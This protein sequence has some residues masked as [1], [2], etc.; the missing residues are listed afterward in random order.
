MSSVSNLFHTN[1][2]KIEFPK[3]L[4]LS[5]QDEKIVNLVFGK[6]MLSICAGL[7]IACAGMSFAAT[8]LYSLGIIGFLVLGLL[9]I[10]ATYK[11][12]GIDRFMHKPLPFQKNQPVGLPNRG[13][14]CWANSALQLIMNNPNLEERFR[15]FEVFNRIID[16]YRRYQDREIAICSEELSSF[17]V[18][19][20]MH[21]ITNGAVDV[22]IAQEDPAVIFENLM[23]TMQTN[24]GQLGSFYTFSQRIGDAEANIFPESMVSVVISEDASLTTSVNSY[25]DYI[26][27]LGRRI[28]R[29]FAESPELLMIEIRRNLFD[30]SPDGTFNGQ[31]KDSREVLVDLDMNLDA[32]KFEDGIERRYQCSGFIVHQ[33]KNP[34]SG[35][36][37][38]Y[39]K[40][41][42]SWWYC[43]DEEVRKAPL[44]EVVIEKNKASFFSFNRI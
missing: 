41:E 26:D 39:V 21:G 9:S 35:H 33:G 19:Y 44:H 38:A 2:W 37:V 4:A 15:N 11:G 7:S 20:F 25:F 40:R 34:R 3:A 29:K 10:G 24:T 12:E 42:G 22:G 27:D 17:E 1:Q 31:I 13:N 18:R 32:D 43:S 28:T 8:P 16:T 5:K 30:F 23:S 36:Y 6:I 14:N